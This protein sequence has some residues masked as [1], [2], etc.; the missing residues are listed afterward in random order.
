MKKLISVLLALI[1]LLSVCII[2]AGARETY[3]DNYYYGTGD[4]YYLNYPTKDEIIAKARELDIDLSYTDGY[5]QDYSL[6][7][8]DYRIGR[9][10]DGTYTQGLNV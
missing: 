5:A 6:D 7:P 10:D 2:S 8:A 1:T 4:P 9:L 3:I